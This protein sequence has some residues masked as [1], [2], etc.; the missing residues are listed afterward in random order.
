MKAI[1][2]Q[3]ELGPHGVGNALQCRTAL[4]TGISLLEDK[5]K[6]YNVTVVDGILSGTAMWG[7]TTITEK[8]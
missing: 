4:E 3:V 1:E 6:A 2:E 8:T 5:Q 7:K